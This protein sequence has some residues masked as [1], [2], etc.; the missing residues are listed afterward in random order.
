MLYREPSR[1]IPTHWPV[2]KKEIESLCGIKINISL[3]RDKRAHK[4][5]SID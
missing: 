3:D 2:M 1:P 5:R 4:Q